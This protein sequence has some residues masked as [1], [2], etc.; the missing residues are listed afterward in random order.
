MFEPDQQKQDTGVFF[1]L[2][3]T[4]YESKFHNSLL[5]LIGNFLR[6]YATFIKLDTGFP[7]VHTIEETLSAEFPQ[8]E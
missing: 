4:F 2:Q 1:T 8:I 7:N 3:L 5:G 6:K